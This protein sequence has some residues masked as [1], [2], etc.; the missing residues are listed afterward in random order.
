MMYLNCFIFNKKNFKEILIMSEIIPGNVL[1]WSISG[2]LF[3]TICNLNLCKISMIDLFIFL[4]DLKIRTFCI[5]TE[6]I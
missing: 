3:W 2:Y 5:L 6:I 4:S 1:L